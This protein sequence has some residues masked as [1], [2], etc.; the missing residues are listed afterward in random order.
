MM[1]FRSHEGFGQV[2]AGA[3]SN[4]G[5]SLPWWAPAPQLLLYGEALG[6]GKVA[7]EATATA[8]CREPRFQV[9]PG[10]QALLDPPVPPAPKASAAERGSLPEVLKFS[11]AQ[12]KGEKGAEYS[13]TVALPSPFAIYNGRFELG[14]GQ[15]MVSANNPY[16]DQHY[17]LLSPYPV[18][19]TN[20][21]C[22]RI[23]LN[24]PTEAPIYVNAKQYEGI[25]RRR[26][27]RAKAERENRLVK[28]RK[29]YL[30]ES[31]HLHALRRARGSGG[32][33]LN[34]KKES[35]GK[36]AGGDG[37][38]MI[39]KPLMR[40]VASPSSEIQQSDLGNPSSVSSL[41][42]S[43][44]SSIYDHEDVDHYHS[45]DHLRTPFFTPLPS[46]MDGEHGGNP[47]KWPTASEGCCDLLRA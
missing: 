25:I 47:F 5:A 35:N 1:S 17:G 10:A 20:G 26:R 45:F 44:V 11:V 13:A 31:R 36:D 42:G 39:S 29:P 19:A 3:I 12:G 46:I 24:M 43:E 7:P 15:S 30:H 2:P 4:G 27:A 32:R 38:A 40:Q 16:A 14:L 18:G 21:G 28:A 9:V 23:P 6:Q 37:K 8:A 33:F 22:T 41:S 34:T